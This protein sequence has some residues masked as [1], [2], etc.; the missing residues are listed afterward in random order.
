[1]KVFDGSPNDDNEDHQNAANPDYAK[2][3]PS[4]D[5]EE[6]SN[7]RVKRCATDDENGEEICD[8]EEISDTHQLT[9]VNTLGENENTEKITSNEETEKM[10]EESCSKQKSKV[11]NMKH[12]IRVN[13]FF[14][15]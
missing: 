10:E 9:Q 12:N 1:M 11:Q 7:Y 2:S 5:N 14:L 4:Y 8:E 15:I 3:S 13:K 6:E